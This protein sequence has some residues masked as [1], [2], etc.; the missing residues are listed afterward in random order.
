M[1][2]GGGIK[3]STTIKLINAQFDRYI[4]YYMMNDKSTMVMVKG[5][6]ANFTLN[7]GTKKK[8]FKEYKKFL[9]GLPKQ[10]KSEC[11]VLN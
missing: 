11:E 2:L 8:I 7:V 4:D 1:I 10:Y 9:Q 6:N 3:L 5:R